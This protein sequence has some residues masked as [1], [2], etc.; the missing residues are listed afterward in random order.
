MGG[1]ATAKEVDG[2]IIIEDPNEERRLPLLRKDDIVVELGD[3]KDDDVTASDLLNYVDKIVV[4]RL[5]RRYY[6][7]AC[8]R[9]KFKGLKTKVEA[10]QQQRRRLVGSFGDL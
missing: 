4:E 8:I 9:V 7:D 1:G 6:C 5:A 3:K 2:K 10:G